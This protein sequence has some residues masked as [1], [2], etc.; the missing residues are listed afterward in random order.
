MTKAITGTVALTKT[1]GGT[2]TSRPPILRPRCRRGLLINAGGVNVN[3]TSPPDR[4]SSGTLGGKE[5]AAAGTADGKRARRDRRRSS[6]PL[7]LNG[8][9]RSTPAPPSIS[10]SAPASPTPSPRFAHPQRRNRHHHAQ[11]QRSRRPDQR[12][13]QPS[14]IPTCSPASPPSPSDRTPPRELIR[15]STAAS[16]SCT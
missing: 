6:T 11:P 7:T 5:P 10:I 12:R 8:T 9:S 15:R 4:A 14:G 2:L 16:S 13:L 3:G 1:G